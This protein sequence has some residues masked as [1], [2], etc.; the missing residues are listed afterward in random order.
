MLPYIQ[1]RSEEGLEAKKMLLSSEINL[2]NLARIIQNWKKLRKY[3]LTKKTR[4]RSELKALSAKIN[5]LTSEMPEVEGVQKI[6]LVKESW[7][8]RKKDSIEQEL[9]SIR[10]KLSRIS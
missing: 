10:E 5:S 8:E 2:L 6:H 9:A 4:L 3:E 7:R 1:V